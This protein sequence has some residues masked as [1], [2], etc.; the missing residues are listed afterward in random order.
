M[1][2][3][4]IYSEQAALKMTVQWPMTLCTIHNPN[5]RKKEREKINL[6]LIG[7]WS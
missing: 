4:I 3:S 5:A 7:I 6:I 2:F 1:L